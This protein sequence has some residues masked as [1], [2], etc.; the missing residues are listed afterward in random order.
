MLNEVRLMGNLG[1]DPELKQTQSGQSVLRLRMATSESWNDKQTGQR[2]ET[3]EWH[4]VILWGNRA[5]PLANML[6]KGET[7]LVLGK[8][9][10]NEW[11]D[12]QTGQKRV[13]AEIKAQDIKLLGKREKRQQGV[14]ATDSGPQWNQPPPQQQS[15]NNNQYSDDIPF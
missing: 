15:A 8:L 14:Q 11:Q 4:T 9:T 3:T 6:K 5:A 7:V 12:K 13:T 1:M 2:K 10:Y